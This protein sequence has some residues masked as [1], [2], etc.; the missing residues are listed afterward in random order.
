MFKALSDK[1]ESIF[2]KLT[3]AGYVREADVDA[4]LRE[5]R[6][7]LLE[8]DVALEVVREFTTLA[9]ERAVGEEVIKSI[10]PGQMVVKVVNDVLVELLTFEN[11]ELSLASK[12][13]AVILML[14]LQGSG[15]TTTTAKLAY[16]LKKEGKKV[17]VVSLDVARPAAQE[18]LAVLASQADVDCLEI[19]RGEGATAIAKRA[20]KVG[21]L[22]DVIILDTAGRLHI[23][24]NLMH[25][26]KEIKNITHPVESILV[27]DS[28]TGQDAANIAKTFNAEIGISG[29]IL[30]R[31]DSDARGGAA[32]SIS[33]VT[34]CPI[35]FLGAGEK[36]QDL[37]EFHP[38]RLVSRILGMGDVVSLV[39]RASQAIDQ[40]ESDKIS[41]KLQKGHF[42]LSIY[43]EQLKSLKKMGGIASVVGMLPG[44]GKMM[45]NAR[46]DMMDD[47]SVTRQLAIIS[48]MTKEERLIPKIL[49]ASRKIR[50]A[51]G[52]GTSVQDVNK[53]VKQFLQA[54]KVLATS[55]Q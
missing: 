26:L 49:N 55:T 36:L 14:G 50:V 4:A 1:L 46:P 47:K 31:I 48:S 37:E 38:D 20:L 24:S 16:K 39:E 43:A 32:L 21:Y 27:A 44:M 19:V 23:D 11:T 33:Y 51:N 7:A 25:E 54:L 53:L 52:S 41:K 45:S 29:I 6:V 28:L 22:H 34:K 13:P 17:L 5:I 10:T 15:K 40:E 3:G 9:K 42:D 2:D 30:T 12:P 18:Q 35:K 8:A